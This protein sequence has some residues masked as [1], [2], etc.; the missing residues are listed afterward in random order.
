MHSLLPENP[1]LC[2]WL[3][4]LSGAGKTTLCAAVEPRLIALGHRV[5]VLD[6]DDLR[7]TI[8]RDLGFSKADRD[9]NVSRLASLARDLVEQGFIV[10]VAAI[11]PYRC[12]REQARA[13]IGNFLEVYV[14]APLSLC[15]HRDP[16]HLYARALAGQLPN[17]TGLDDPYEA[18]ITPDV[19]CDTAHEDIEHCTARILAAICTARSAVPAGAVTDS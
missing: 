8:S 5:R 14:D 11:S 2:L 3:T 18:P 4:G 1:G 10:L 16:K 6:G 15:I 7:R 13:H 19:Q 12:A 9:E 17:F